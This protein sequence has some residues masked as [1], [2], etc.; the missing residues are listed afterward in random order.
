MSEI[1]REYEG[2]G[3]VVLAVNV[4]DEE[5]A[6]RAHV[7]DSGHDLRWVRADDAAVEAFGLKGVPTYVIIDREGRVRW[8]SGFFSLFRGA[9]AVRDNLDRALEE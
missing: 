4:W 7:E 3:V 5:S 8:T 2:C 9:A 6:F 1:G